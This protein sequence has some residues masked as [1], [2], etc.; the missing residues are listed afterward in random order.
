MKAF[1]WLL[2]MFGI[3][4]GLFICATMSILGAMFSYLFIPPTRNKSIYELETMFI[5]SS[6]LDKT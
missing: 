5:G 3:G 1:P 4:G 2:D 6:K